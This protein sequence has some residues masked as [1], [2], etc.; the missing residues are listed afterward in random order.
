MMHKVPGPAAV[1]VADGRTE[2][3][4][5]VFVLSNLHMTDCSGATR[6]ILHVSSSS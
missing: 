4:E 2:H 5:E 3:T 1:F 6:L